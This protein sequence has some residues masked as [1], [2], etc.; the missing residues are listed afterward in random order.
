MLKVG[1]IYKTPA[2]DLVDVVQIYDTGYFHYDV[3]TTGR[4]FSQK[5]GT[6]ESWERVEPKE[7]PVERY[8]RHRRTLSKLW[9]QNKS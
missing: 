6:E 8:K 7:T 2:G 4:R 5:I 1:Q 3:R 9:P